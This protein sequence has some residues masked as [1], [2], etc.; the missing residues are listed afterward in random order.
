MIVEPMTEADLGEVLAIDLA[1]FPASQHALA[2]AAGDFRERREGQLREELARPWA[3]LR[4]AREGGEGGGRV[5]GYI[6][7]WHVV[8]EVH[9]LD[10]AVAPGERRKGIGRALVE[11][12][13]GYVA[14]NAAVKVLLEVRAG[15]EAAIAL[16][17]KLGFAHLGVRARYYDDGEDAVEMILQKS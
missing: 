7:F 14:E 1:S 11:H 12:M 13:L 4:V 3:R 6:L 5:V 17:E 16:Y 15:N 9:L 8:D 10:V 2:S